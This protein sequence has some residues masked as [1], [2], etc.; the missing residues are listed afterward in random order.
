MTA[1][2][3]VSEIIAGEGKL[4]FE[5]TN[6]RFA[7]RWSVNK[8]DLKKSNNDT[9]I[10]IVQQ[11]TIVNYVFLENASFSVIEYLVTCSGHPY[12]NCLDLTDKEGFSY[13]L[14]SGKVPEAINYVII[15]TFLKDN[16]KLSNIS[17]ESDLSN[18]ELVAENQAS[19][20]I[21]N[22][23]IDALEN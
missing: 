21:P 23:A 1:A 16:L 15:D 17:A 10:S 7:P 19:I 5:S 2:I 13:E 12:Y 3:F 9:G 6:A 18:Q 11:K 14:V 8:T 22:N 4:L 20:Q